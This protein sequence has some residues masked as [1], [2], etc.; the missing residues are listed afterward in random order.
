MSRDPMFGK[1]F[2][3]FLVTMVVGGL[4]YSIISFAYMHTT[5]STKEAFSTTKRRIDRIEPRLENR[6]QSI[7]DKLDR[8]IER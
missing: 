3:L 1:E 2:W 5:F 8:L 4:T 6:L 7:E